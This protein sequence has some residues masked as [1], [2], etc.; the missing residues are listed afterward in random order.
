M[1]KLGLPSAGIR[2]HGHQ[3]FTSLTSQCTLSPLSAEGFA[4]HAAGG[5]APGRYGCAGCTS[6]VQDE[7]RH[8]AVSRK[9][10]TGLLPRPGAA[11]TVTLFPSLPNARRPHAV[12]PAMLTRLDNRTAKVGGWLGGSLR[13]LSPPLVSAREHPLRLDYRGD[14]RKP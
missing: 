4:S 14:V 13:Q 8:L 3:A 12:G 7:A 6:V 5:P 11:G 9:P 10:G 1:G 2:K